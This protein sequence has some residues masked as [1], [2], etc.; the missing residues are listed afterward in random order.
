[1]RGFRTIALGLLV[2]MIIVVGTAQI[3]A[4]YAP[5]FRDAGLRQEYVA[6]HGV[7]PAG[8]IGHRSIRA[9]LFSTTLLSTH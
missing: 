9:A 7:D 4:K 2:G 6:A 1:M 5:E 8:G 3:S